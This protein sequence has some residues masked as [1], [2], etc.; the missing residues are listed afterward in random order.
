[1]KK[2]AKT[3]KKAKS[4]RRTSRKKKLQPSR[5]EEED[6]LTGSILGASVSAAAGSAAPQ[7]RR[8]GER[9]LAARVISTHRKFAPGTDRQARSEED[10]AQIGFEP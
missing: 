7:G 10:R 3:K 1:M 8:L 4:L 5:A 6:F 9:I 2:T